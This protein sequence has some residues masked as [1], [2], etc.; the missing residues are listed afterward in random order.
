MKTK[1][2]PNS[3]PAARCLNVQQAA[4]YVGTTAWQIR[5]LVWAKELTHIKLGQRLLFDVRDLDKFIE[6]QKVV[7]RA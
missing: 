4:A 6:S 5:K 3:A 1:A 2:V 7:A